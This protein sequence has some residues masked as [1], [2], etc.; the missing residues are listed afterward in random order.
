[1]FRV[2]LATCRRPGF[3]QISPQLDA[4]SFFILAN[5]LCLLPSHTPKAMHYFPV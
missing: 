3:L 5:I 4:L 1:M 2:N